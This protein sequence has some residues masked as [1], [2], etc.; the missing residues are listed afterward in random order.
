MINRLSMAHD[1]VVERHG[2]E[3]RKFTN[4]PY[5]IHLEETAQ[6]LWEA[7]DGKASDDEYIAALFHDL[8]ENTAT[9]PEEIGQNYGGEVMSM[10]VEVTNDD[11]Q[12][13]KEGKAV[14]L[15]KKIN[16]MSNKAFSL[17]LCDRLSNVVGLQDKRIPNSFV[18]RYVKET[19]YII[20]HIDREIDEI[21]KYLIGRI[22]NMLLFLRLERNL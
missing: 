10:V 4:I 17:K 22:T 12:I 8:L 11:T 2:D 3:K 20:E 14:Y 21:Q 18:A 6:L 15:V 7:T 1:F 19:H 16:I 5:V 13:A 9:T